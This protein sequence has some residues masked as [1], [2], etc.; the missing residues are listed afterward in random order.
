MCVCLTACVRARALAR[1]CVCKMGSNPLVREGVVAIV[2]THHELL[3]P[4]VRAPHVVVNG[5]A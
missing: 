1:A 2:V 5:V 3:R 4:L